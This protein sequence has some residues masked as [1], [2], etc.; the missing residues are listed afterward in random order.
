[1]QNITSRDYRFFMLIAVLIMVLN[2]CVQERSVP[3][4]IFIMSDDHAGSAISAYGGRLNHTPNIDRIAEEGV[5]FTSSFVSNSICAPARAAI[6]TG[7]FSHQC[8]QIDNLGV[9]DGTQQTFPKIFRS[10][11][12]NTAI[13]GKWHLK[14]AP[15]GFDYWNVLPGQGYYYD[16]EFINNGRD[17][18]YEGYVTDITT[19]LAIEW[20]DELRDRN[21]PFC[22]LVQH[23]APHRNWMPDMKYFSL[24]EDSVFQPPRTFKDDFSDASKVFRIQE[25]SIA[26]HMMLDRDCKLIVDE[27]GDTAEYVI[28]DRWV[29]RMDPEQKQAWLSHYSGI[30]EEFYRQLPRGKE[31]VSWKF[32]RYLSDYLACIQSVDDGVG[33]ILDYLDGHD[34]AE[35]T[36]VVYTSDQ[37]FFLGEHGLF[38]KRLMY[39]ES[40]STPLIMRYPGKISPGTVCEE[41]V[42]NIDYAPSFLD[43]A[44]MDI[45]PD[46]QGESFAP[47][48]CGEKKSGRNAIYYHYYEFPSTSFIPRHYG[49]RTKRYKLIHFYYTI[50]EWELYDLENDPS[51]TENIYADHK[52]TELVENLKEELRALR[53]RYKDPEENDQYFIDQTM[54]IPH[55]RLHMEKLKEKNYNE[56]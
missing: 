49:I 22:L 5:L 8:G 53:E 47:V 56:L 30:T 41:L 11:G 38:D 44:G 2:S 33:R 45:P 7:K 54:Q 32:N 6:L 21:K 43:F 50:D 10:N 42:Q 35:N 17:T 55:Y 51:E 52:D 27:N 12:Y 37:G 25:Q 46:M 3:N 23:K 24:M 9:F 40:I 34:L 36:I 1:M 26:W 19:D 13:V 16:P 20:L 31:L 39:E 28:S 15:T 14:S 29:N 18:I 48:V 4:I